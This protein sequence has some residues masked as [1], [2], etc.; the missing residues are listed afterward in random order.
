MAARAVRWRVVIGFD[1]DSKHGWRIAINHPE[2]PRIQLGE[3]TLR[4]RALGTSGPANQFF[5]LSRRSL[6]AYHRP[7]TGWPPAVC[8]HYRVDP[9]A[10]H[11]DALATGLF[12]MGIEKAMPIARPIQIQAC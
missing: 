11:A 6:R 9:S 10:T 8:Q 3:L 4:D 1:L 7:R 12:V 2:Q 5:L